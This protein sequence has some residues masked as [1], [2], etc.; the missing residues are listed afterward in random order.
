M[1]ITLVST[2]VSIG[3]NFG[4]TMT[5]NFNQPIKELIWAQ[6]LGGT[7]KTLAP[8]EFT[9]ATAATANLP[10]NHYVSIGA[11]ETINSGTW[12][13]K[14]N[15]HERFSERPTEYFT[16]SQIWQHHTGYGST[17]N[18]NGI[19][20]YSFAI[21]PEEHQPSGTCNFSRID[22]AQLVTSINDQNFNVYAVNY[23]VLRIMSGMGGLAY[24]N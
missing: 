3:T 11:E 6:P 13:L 18:P 7:I 8:S 9:S 10:L 20:V 15:G 23:N 14:L 4:G 24:S 2:L 22:N 16:R 12:I 1:A 5:L 19:A 17:I 21:K